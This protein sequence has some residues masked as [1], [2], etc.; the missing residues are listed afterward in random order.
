[1]LLALISHMI[2]QCTYDKEMTNVIKYVEYYPSKRSLKAE[3]WAN[4]RIHFDYRYMD[5]SIDDGKTC[6]TV[7]QQVVFSW[8]RYTC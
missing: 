5:G 4:I 7:G 2:H 3:T 1:M 8:T 6:K